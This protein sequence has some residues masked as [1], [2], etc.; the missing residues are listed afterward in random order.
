MFKTVAVILVRYGDAVTVTVSGGDSK[1]GSLPKPLKLMFVQA[2][3]FNYYIFVMSI[4]EAWTPRL[5][6][7][8]YEHKW[9]SDNCSDPPSRKVS[10]VKRGGAVHW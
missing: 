5:S 4:V 9:I 3:D 7:G 10:R 2:Q 8:H 1:V 6:G